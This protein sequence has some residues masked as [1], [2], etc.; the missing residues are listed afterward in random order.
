MAIPVIEYGQGEEA[1]GGE[2]PP[3]R[4]ISTQQGT[5]GEPMALPK[6]GS[7]GR[8]LRVRQQVDWD[9]H[10]M[11]SKTTRGETLTKI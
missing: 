9:T 10:R 8:N 4:R 11:S 2:I 6:T 1:S 7:V 5:R 3:P